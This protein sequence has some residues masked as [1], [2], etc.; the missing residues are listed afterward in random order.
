MLFPRF[1]AHASAHDRS[2]RDAIVGHVLNLDPADLRIGL[3]VREVFE[4]IPDPDGG[5]TIHLPQWEVVGF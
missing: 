2:V 5:E 4:E 3:P 1:Y